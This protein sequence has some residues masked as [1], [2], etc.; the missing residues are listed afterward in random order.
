MPIVPVYRLRA[1]SSEKSRSRYR[2]SRD[3][4]P[5]PNPFPGRRNPDPSTSWSIDRVA[6]YAWS[7]PLVDGRVDP[8][9]QPVYEFFRLDQSNRVQYQYSADPSP[10]DGWHA[11]D[12]VSFWAYPS[13]HL[14][15]DHAVYTA[16][17]ES[18]NGGTAKALSLN[19]YGLANAKRQLA[20]AFYAS[21]TIPIV[22]SVRENPR[23][24][25]RFEWTFEPSTVHL[26]HPATLQFTRAPHSSW[27]FTGFE[28]V[29]GGEDFGSPDVT[30]EMV[31][32]DA[33]Y[34]TQDRD[35]KY[36][37]TIAVGDGSRTITGDPEI[38]NQTPD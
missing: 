21:A 34:R 6:F 35:F 16:A 32:V 15:A 37:I 27:K 7:D 24:P 22:V 4:H 38:V 36:H 25:D 30:D 28:V 26:S 8:E 1:S 13:A 9:L 23:S 3:P 19:G 10:P 31:L 29:D 11:R 20:P 18:A 5:D 14:D 17:A 12:Y 33:H 2:F